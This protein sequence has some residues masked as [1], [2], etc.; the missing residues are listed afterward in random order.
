MTVANSV[1]PYF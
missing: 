1:L